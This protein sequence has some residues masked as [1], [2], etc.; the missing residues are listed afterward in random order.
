[1]HS[2]ND[3]KKV[4]CV[5]LGVLRVCGLWR[6]VASSYTS[7][8]TIYGTIFLAIFSGFYTLF[9]CIH[10]A[11][12]TDLNQLTDV[13]YM[14]LTE[15][16]LFVKIIIFFILNRKLQALY[17]ELSAFKLETNDERTFVACR[18]NFFFKAMVFY[19]SVSNGATSLTEISTVLS[20]EWRLPYAGWYPFVDW[21]HSYTGYWITFAYQ[22]FGMHVTCNLNVTVDTFA[23]FFMFIISVQMEVLGMR[24]QTMGYGKQSLGAAAGSD[25]QDKSANIR[26]LVAQ[27]KLHQAMLVSTKKFE[28][29]FS[30]AF[31]TQI[32]FSGMVICSLTNELANVS[33]PPTFLFIETF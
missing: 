22:M 4:T 20:N 23:T 32:S 7:L 1:M 12:L 17:A 31:F 13:S 14:A 25:T 30:I 11:I 19:Y 10:L 9:M 3:L 2:P 8:Y 18:V 24:L 21:Q 28:G 16:A 26:R 33:T 6:P 15:L 29:Y 27:I 5:L